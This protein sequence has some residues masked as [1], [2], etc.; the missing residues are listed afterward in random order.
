MRSS[1]TRRAAASSTKRRWPRRFAQGRLGGAALDVF[2]KEPLPAGSPLAGCP[3]L[4]LTPHIAG[5]TAESNERVSAM[6]AERVI[7]SACQSKLTTARMPRYALET[8]THAG[9]ARARARRRDAVDGGGDGAR[10]GRC[11]CARA[12]LAWRVARPA[13]R[14]ASAQRPRG[15]RCAT[16]RRARSAEAWR[17]SMPAADSRFR[18]ARSPSRPRSGAHATAASHSSASRTAIISARRRCTCSRWREA[19]MVG[20]AFGNSPAAMSAAGG[21]TPLFGTNPIAAIFPRR[22]AQPLTD[23]P[24]A[25][26]SR[27]RQADG[28]REGRQADSARMGARSR[29]RSDDGCRRR[30]SKARCC[31][32]AVRRARCLRSSSSCWS[33][34]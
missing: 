5:V 33:P 24:V 27:A 29:R 9:D 31:P 11:G 28:R 7:A 10:A 18:R 25:V 3:N 19:G 32:R 4:L 13:I 23:R 26:G 15:R 30:A 22:D 16:A 14:D 17:S 12:R 1:S 6:I 8:L 34:R 2:D 20:L 21:R